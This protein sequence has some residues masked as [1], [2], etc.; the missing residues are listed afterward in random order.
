MDLEDRYATGKLGF[1]E[2]L[3]ERKELSRKRDADELNADDW[4]FRPGRM[5][6]HEAAK[7]LSRQYRRKRKAQ[8]A[9]AGGQ[10]AKGNSTIRL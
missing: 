7:I 9:S 1:Q 6:E 4:S 8:A 2:Y 10:R 5:P 3:E